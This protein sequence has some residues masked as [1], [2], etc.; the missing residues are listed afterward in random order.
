MF[1]ALNAVRDEK[2]KTMGPQSSLCTTSKCFGDNIMNLLTEEMRFIHCVYQDGTLESSG[3]W[4]CPFG[5]SNA[6]SAALAELC[7]TWD[8]CKENQQFLVD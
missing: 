2:A 8:M 6:E 7:Q 4:L 3:H 1:L 5:T